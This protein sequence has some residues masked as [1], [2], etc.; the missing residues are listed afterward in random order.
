MTPRAGVNRIED[1]RFGLRARGTSAEKVRAH[2]ARVD[3][4]D[5]NREQDHRL[6]SRVKVFEYPVAHSCSGSW[7]IPKGLT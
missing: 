1:G 4:A 2:R 5:D 3:G 7:N 6:E